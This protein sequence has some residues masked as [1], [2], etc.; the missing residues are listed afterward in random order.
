MWGHKA[1]AC[2]GR[3]RGQLQQLVAHGG[4]A[5]GSLF[6]SW[7]AAWLVACAMHMQQVISVLPAGQLLLLLLAEQPFKHQNSYLVLVWA[8]NARQAC[9]GL[10]VMRTRCLVVVLLLCVGPGVYSKAGCQAVWLQCHSVISLCA[11]C[12]GAAVM[13]LSAAASR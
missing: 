2:C 7:L 9:N 3:V 13:H 1:A 8:S 5:L 12:T 10:V 4:A 6:V 11:T